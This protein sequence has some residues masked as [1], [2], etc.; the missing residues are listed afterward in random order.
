MEHWQRQFIRYLFPYSASRMRIEQA[1]LVKHPHVPQF[2]YK[3][4]EFKT[5]H[6][7]AL[8]RSVLYMSS[9]DRFND[10]FD[11]T[12][13]FDTARFIVEDLPAQEFIEHVKEI[14]RSV[15]SG[16]PWRPRPIKN[17]IR[18]GDWIRRVMAEILK[19]GPDAARNAIMAVAE[20][21][22]QKQSE[23]MRQRT[24]AY[25]RKGF[26]VLSLSAN[27]ASILMWSHYSKAHQGFCIEYNFGRLPPGDQRR[28]LCFPV[29]YR[30]KM[31][32]ATR[33]MANTGATDFNNLIGQYLCLLKSAD[34][35]YEREW[36]IV[37]A[38][39]PA[40]ANREISMPK[41]SAV[42]LGNSA[43]PEDV[44]IMDDF[45][46]AKGITLKRAVQSD[47]APEI[48]IR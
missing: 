35:E 1:F 32:D 31:T 43:K 46:R 36:R 14:D 16:V 44:E 38:I 17:P 41:P 13:F 26:S 3:Y 30:Q 11:T 27:P 24:R 47:S 6:L 7:E 40:Y 18:Q 9:P 22:L 5:S 20:G 12:V 25:L 33:Y 48:I 2:L 4:R 34:W 19:D 29:L 8:E 21:I 28:R 39:G 23:K 15:R 10:P 42:I 45:S 37:H